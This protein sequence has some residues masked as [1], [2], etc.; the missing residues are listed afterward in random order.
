M[1]AVILSAGRGIRMKELTEHTPKPLLEVAGRSLLQYAL[2]ALPDDVDEVIISVGYRGNMIRERF[3]SQ[4]HGKRLLYVEQHHLNGT[5]GALWL[6]KPFLKNSFLVMHADNI[7]AREDVVK[8]ACIPWSVVGLAVDD[9]GQAAK[10]VLDMSKKVTN[11]LEM[12]DYDKSPGFL[13]TGLYCLDTRVFDYPMVPKSPGSEEFG[14][15]QTLVKADIPL[16]LVEATSWYEITTPEDIKKVEEIL[17][18]NTIPDVHRISP[19]EAKK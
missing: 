10:L 11:V 8:A 12:G 2:D 6:A 5:A 16:H 7:Y 4:Y 14:L 17:A 18:K 13:N 15:P 1:Q 9:L 19:F 3:G